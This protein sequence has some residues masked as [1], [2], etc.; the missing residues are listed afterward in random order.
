MR[1]EKTDQMDLVEWYYEKGWT[2]VLACG[3]ANA[4]EGRGDG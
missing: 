1:E 4:R 2:D 3:S